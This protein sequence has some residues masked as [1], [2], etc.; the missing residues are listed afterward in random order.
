MSAFARAAVELHDLD[1][2]KL[3]EAL[4]KKD[5]EFYRMCKDVPEPIARRFHQLD[6]L[7]RWD[8]SEKRIKVI[9]DR[10]TKM[11][12]PDKTVA[13][14]RFE[15]LAELLD[16]ACQ[17]FEIWDEHRERRI[18]F[19]HRL[20]LEARLLESVKDAFDLIESTI[21]RFAEIGED[22][23]AANIERGVSLLFISFNFNF[24]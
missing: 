18:P 9:E 10:M 4:I 6:L 3:K 22:R 8:E 20:V 17:A 15:I 14:D 7:T 21:D 23:D 5:L 1:D 16:K 19:G 12:C 11:D 2:E 24:D 13:E